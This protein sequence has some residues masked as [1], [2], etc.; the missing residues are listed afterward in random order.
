VDL[1][2]LVAAV[3]SLFRRVLGSRITH[4]AVLGG[5]LFAFARPAPTDTRVSLGTDYLRS[6]HAAQAL[7]LGVPSLS[8]ERSFEVDRRAVEDEVLYREAVRLGLDRDDAMVREHLIQKMLLF[9]EDIGGASREPTHEEV[10]AYFEKTRERWQKDERVHLVHV[11]STRREAAASLLEAVRAQDA[12]HPDRPPPLGDA[13]ARSRDVRGAKGDFAESFGDGFAGAVFALPPGAWSDPVESR[14]GWHLVKVLQHTAGTK[15]K[16]DEV[17][18][19]VRLEYAVERRHE[20]IAQFL[21]QAFERYQ[22]LV[23][24]APLPHV[25]P[26]RRLALRSMPSGED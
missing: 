26:T 10:A 2:R 8:D 12:A 5:L 21:A 11:F 7:R 1:A 24:G 9:A 3:R 13:F 18:D 17:Y 23:D 16:L 4:F 14:F 15:A 6:L 22:V 25:E 20:A 19:R